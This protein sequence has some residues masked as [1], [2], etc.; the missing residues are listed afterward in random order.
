MVLALPLLATPQT[1][2]MEQYEYS[3]QLQYIQITGIYDLDGEVIIL[4]QL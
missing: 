1:Q 3:I 2:K 4:T